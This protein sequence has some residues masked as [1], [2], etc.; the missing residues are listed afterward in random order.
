VTG[1]V[2][3][4][5][6]LS[7]ED[8]NGR[9]WREF[10][11]PETAFDPAALRT[12]RDAAVT[13]LHPPTMVTAANHSSLS[14]GHVGDAVGREGIY[15]SAPLVVQD[16]D[17]VA[18]VDAGERRELSAGY[19]CDVEATSGVWQ[20]QAYDGIQRNR[21]YNH[22]ALLPV[23]AGRAGRD[24]ALRLDGAAVQIEAPAGAGAGMK[25]ITIKGKKYR[26]DDAAEMAEAQKTAD[27][28]AVELEKAEGTG[29]ENDDLKAK[30]EAV[31]SALTDA[32]KSAAVASA[33]LAAKEA[34][35]PA[36]VTE[37]N[38]PEEVQDAIAVKR[39]KL[40]EDARK[41]LGAD[42]ELPKTTKGIHEAVIKLRMP[43]KKLDG[44][45]EVVRLAHFDALVATATAAP[46]KRRNDG[47]AALNAGI[48]QNA[49]EAARAD[50]DDP[51]EAARARMDSN[52]RKGSTDKKAS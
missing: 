34:V 39:L 45:S 38:V 26:V 11:P 2:A 1:N 32:L 20:G 35:E 22:V 42:A 52:T 49:E 12:L 9:K 5:G 13:D 28:M 47:L 23:G 46:P 48:R 36:P 21:V 14:K 6:V 15:V 8:T 30:L 37:E 41:V 4:V 33:A 40:H 44:M 16:A 3:K 50:G 10:V 31:Q 51:V 7:Y 43:E 29:A 25:F 24:V 27:D 18:K 19:T 17:L